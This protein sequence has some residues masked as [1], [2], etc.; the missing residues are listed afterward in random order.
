MLLDPSVR[1]F[2]KWCNYSQEKTGSQLLG[3]YIKNTFS[4]VLFGDYVEP[5][6]KVFASVCQLSAPGP[7]LQFCPRLSPRLHAWMLKEARGRTG[8]DKDSLCVPF[9]SEI[10][11]AIKKL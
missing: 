1:L 9:L 2:R 6:G 5:A 8:G 3:I 4:L 11:Y 10:L 7:L